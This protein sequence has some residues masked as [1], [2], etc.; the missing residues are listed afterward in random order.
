M[1]GNGAKIANLSEP[2]LKFRRVNGFYKRRGR[3]KSINELKA[4]FQAMK[5][6]NQWSILNISYAL[7]V[8]ILRMMPEDVLKFAYKIDRRLIRK[9]TKSL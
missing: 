2:L 4:R 7:M 9:E 8:F 5:M 3:G 1:V 6:L